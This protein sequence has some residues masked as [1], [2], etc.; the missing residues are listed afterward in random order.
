MNRSHKV[1]ASRWVIPGSRLLLAFLGRIRRY[2]KYREVVRYA[3]KRL[4]SRR[5]VIK[6]FNNVPPLRRDDEDSLPDEALPSSV[7]SSISER[8]REDD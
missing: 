7:G 1:N 2:N 6:R 8:S 4:P 5:W 3:P